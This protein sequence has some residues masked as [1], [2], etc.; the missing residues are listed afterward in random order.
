MQIYTTSENDDTR[1][2]ESEWLAEIEAE[3]HHLNQ[4]GFWANES[5][6]GVEYEFNSTP[7]EY[8]DRLKEEGYFV[9]SEPLEYKCK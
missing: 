1:Q 5:G 6:E 8:F 4:I 9:I 7:Q 2:T 3:G